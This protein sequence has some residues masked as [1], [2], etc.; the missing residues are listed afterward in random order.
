MFRGQFLHSID[1]KGRVSLPARF[2]DLIAAGSDQRVVLSPSPFDPCLRVYPMPAWERFELRLSGL[3]SV[4][5]QTMKFRRML[6]GAVDCEI[7]RAGRV[8]VPENL[9]ERAH[10]EK[11]ALCVGMGEF[12]ELWSKRDFDDSLEMNADE[13][14]ELRVAMEQL[15]L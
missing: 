3:S 1:A 6:S 7:D 5:A 9:R 11:E 15:G 13:M 12:V 10:L 4:Q 8:L 14:R 2:R